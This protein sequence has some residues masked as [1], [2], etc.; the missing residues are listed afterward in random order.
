MHISG[1]PIPVCIRGGGRRS[2]PPCKQKTTSLRPKFKTP[3]ICVHG[4][5][6]AATKT[7]FSYTYNARIDSYGDDKRLDFP[8]KK[9]WT[10]A[11]ATT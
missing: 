9:H 11:W 5:H 8:S 4:K 6:V 3:E 7:S 1:D 10:G 2:I